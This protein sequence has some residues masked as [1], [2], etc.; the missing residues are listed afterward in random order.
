MHH[1]EQPKERVVFSW[2]GGKDS[3]MALHEIL[4][5]GRFQVVALLTSIA[6]EYRRVSHHGVREELLE[7]QAEAIGLPL[8]S[9]ICRHPLRTPVPTRSMSN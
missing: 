4:Q 5:S 2:S 3:A 6:Q 1:N 7:R 9:C 8:D